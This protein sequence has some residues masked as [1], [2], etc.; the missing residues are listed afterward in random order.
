MEDIVK[1]GIILGVIAAI[2]FALGFFFV[3]LR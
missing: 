3:V 2:M 1:I